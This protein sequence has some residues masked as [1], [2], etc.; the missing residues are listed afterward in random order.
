M[1]TSAASTN[2]SI[3]PP[4]GSLGTELARLQDRPLAIGLGLGFVVGLAGPVLV[5]LAVSG[6]IPTPDTA[7]PWLWF[8]AGVCI[9]SFLLAT[10][11]AAFLPSFLLGSRDRTAFV[12]HAWIGAREV[13]RLLGSASAAVNI[14]T[15]PEAADKWLATQ[16]D[17]ERLLPL[18]FELLLMTRRFTEARAV[19]DRFPRTTPFD[20]Y[21][22]AEASA[23]VDDQETGQAD[24]HAV[25]DALTLIPRGTDRSEATA[26]LAVFEARQTGRKR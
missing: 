15:T 10:A 20:N 16:P 3:S 14:P 6:G 24:L 9:G 22:V 5:G 17:N 13:R 1:E 4:L 26:S 21:R 7:L 12:V 19:I 18:R 8:A 11:I 25:R 23:M 2:G